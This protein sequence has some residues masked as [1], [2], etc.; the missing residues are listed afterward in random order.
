MKAIKEIKNH[1]I[2]HIEGYNFNAVHTLKNG[3]TF[4]YTFQ[5]DFSNSEVYYTLGNKVKNPT[6][7]GWINNNLDLLATFNK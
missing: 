6:V 1:K 2:N 5:V 3:A 7:K 4:T